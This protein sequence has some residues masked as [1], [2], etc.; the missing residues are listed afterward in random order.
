MNEI[1]TPTGT[2]HMHAWFVAARAMSDYMRRQFEGARDEEVAVLRGALIVALHTLLTMS[3]QMDMAS[4]HSDYA[5]AALGMVAACGM[6][7][8]EVMHDRH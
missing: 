4:F 8:E 1:I 7:E 6:S 3:R 2:Q 5:R